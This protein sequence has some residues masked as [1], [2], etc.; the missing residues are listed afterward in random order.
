MRDYATMIDKLQTRMLKKLR[1]NEHKLSWKNLDLY[2]LMLGLESEHTELKEAAKM[3]LSSPTP[4]N[5][6]ALVDECADLANF[7]GFIVDNM[8]IDRKRKSK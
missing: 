3:V 6:E 1:Q 7:C 8:L 5:I 4:E 2:D